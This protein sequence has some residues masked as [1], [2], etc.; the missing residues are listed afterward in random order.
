MGEGH[1]ERVRR[2]VERLTWVFTLGL[3]VFGAVFLLL[4]LPL[5]LLVFGPSAAD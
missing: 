1:G 3:L 4:L 2:A 5:G